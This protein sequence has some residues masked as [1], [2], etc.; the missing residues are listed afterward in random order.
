MLLRYAAPWR[1]DAERRAAIRRLF[2]QP[3]IAAPP[4]LPRAPFDMLMFA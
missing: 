2:C 1:H 4:M 3:A